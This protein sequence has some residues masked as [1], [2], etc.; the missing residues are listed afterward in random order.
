[1]QRRN[2]YIAKH[3]GVNVNYDTNHV[4]ENSLTTIHDVK[5]AETKVLYLAHGGIKPNMTTLSLS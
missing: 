5:I 2:I 4:S 3:N 1:M